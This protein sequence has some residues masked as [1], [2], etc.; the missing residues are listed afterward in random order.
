MLQ[1][2]CSWTY[3]WMTFVD[4]CT[5]RKDVMTYDCSDFLVHCGL[6]S[7]NTSCCPVCDVNAHHT[8]VSRDTYR[9]WF[10]RIDEPLSF[11]YVHCVSFLHQNSKNGARIICWMDIYVQTEIFLMKSKLSFIHFTKIEKLNINDTGVG[12]L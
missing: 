9:F 2:L 10:Y 5:L 6:T 12:T 11:F 4:R 3:L 7:L 8:L 1:P